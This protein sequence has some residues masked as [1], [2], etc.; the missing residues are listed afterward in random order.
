MSI[1]AGV[2]GLKRR[3]REALERAGI[4]QAELAKS[5]GT[6][7][8]TVSAWLATHRPD[9]PTARFFLELP[10]ALDVSGHWLLTGE[11][12]MAPPTASEGD[13]Y[14]RGVEEGLRQAR[15]RVAEALRPA[16]TGS[17]EVAEDRAAIAA[18][19]AADQ[20]LA[21][22]DRLERAALAQRTG[23]TPA[24]RAKGRRGRAAG[25]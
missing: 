4:G 22:V 7:Q 1:P 11:G 15:V 21:E 18:A 6:G 17:D 8:G 10:A 2:A 19:E 12:P 20:E 9:V 14:R 13:T 25:E 5:V 3:L 23:A 24:P 16:P